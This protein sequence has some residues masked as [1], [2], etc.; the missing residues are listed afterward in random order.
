MHA[1]IET[2]SEPGLRRGLPSVAGDPCNAGPSSKMKIPAMV[3]IALVLSS[4]SQPIKRQAHFLPVMNEGFHAG[5][6][7][8][9]GKVQFIRGED[10]VDYLTPEMKE[11]PEAT[12]SRQ[13]DGSVVVSWISTTKRPE[14]LIYLDSGIHPDVFPEESIVESFDLDAE[15]PLG[16]PVVLSNFGPNTAFVRSAV[17]LRPRPVPTKPRQAAVS[18]PPST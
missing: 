10:E 2:L 16:D 17:D 5:M 9:S 12:V 18:P 7:L 14:K 3:L 15:I 11:P 8:Y 6:V 1:R 4:C 13:A